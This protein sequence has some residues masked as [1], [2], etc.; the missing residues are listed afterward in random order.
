[1]LE[2][3][4]LNARNRSE[5]R[6]PIASA[7]VWET[8]T[9]S[10]CGEFTHNGLGDC[11]RNFTKNHSAMPQSCCESLP[12]AWGQDPAPRSVFQLTPVR[13]AENLRCNSAEDY[14]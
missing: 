7:A 1:M 3:S 6:E 9:L 8:C 2:L 13:E 12:A 14:N 5:P 11:R 4:C 10:G